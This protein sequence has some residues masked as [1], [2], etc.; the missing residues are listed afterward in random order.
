[1][2]KGGVRD[3]LEVDNSGII[4]ENGGGGGSGEGG[5][6]ERILV[7]FISCTVI[8][9]VLIV[10]EA[11]N[12][13]VMGCSMGGGDWRYLTAGSMNCRTNDV[14]PSPLSRW[15]A[16]S[17][18]IFDLFWGF[19]ILFLLTNNGVRL[20]SYARPA[21]S[22]ALSIYALFS[23]AHGFG[24]WYTSTPSTQT[25]GWGDWGDPVNGAMA[26]LPKGGRIALIFFLFIF[27]LIGMLYFVI[28]GGIVI[29]SKFAGC[30]HLEDVAAH[31][32]RMFELAFIPY[33]FGALIPALCAMAWQSKELIYDSSLIGA[34]F[35][36]IWIPLSAFCGCGPFLK[37]AH[38]VDRTF[39]T[40][41]VDGCCN[42]STSA[43]NTM[44]MVGWGLAAVAMLV[45]FIGVLG[46]GLPRYRFK[47][48][49]PLGVVEPSAAWGQAA[50]ATAE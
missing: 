4:G 41:E 46:P 39:F 20:F 11:M 10:H 36:Y 12:H 17:G 5:W 45:I 29:L 47:D 26:G 3:P 27:G 44:T 42:L 37:L 2:G 19:L 23:I 16:A 22:Y 1:M 14:I 40:L 38:S 50:S 24:L 6:G 31:R 30:G 7:L 15:T 43:S 13:G 8:P 25:K 28:G 33:F 49:V 35:F 18:A 48:G 9:L 21:M 34:M 32:C